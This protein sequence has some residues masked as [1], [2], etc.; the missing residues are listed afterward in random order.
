M[1]A[2]GWLFYDD[3]K[4]TFPRGTNWEIHPLTSLVALAK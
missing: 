3:A 2:T 4:V 1:R